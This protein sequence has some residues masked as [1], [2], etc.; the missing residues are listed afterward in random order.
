MIKN[1]KNIIESDRKYDLD[2]RPTQV[3]TL[4]DYLLRPATGFPIMLLCFT[5]L[6]AASFILG[7]PISNLLG[8]GL[9]RL[10]AVFESWAGANRF[11]LLFTSLIS[12]GIFRGIGSALAFFPQMLIFYVFYSAIN[13]TGYAQRMAYIMHSPMSR[14]NMDSSG[15]ACLFIGYSCNVPAVAATRDIPQRIDRLILMLVSTFTPCSARL[16]VILYIAAAFFTPLTA[17]LVMT[18]LIALS[19]AVSAAVA[20]AIKSRF[21][22]PEATAIKLTLPPLHRPKASHVVKSALIRTMDFLNKIKNVVI[23]SA[24]LV[25]FLSTFPQ[26]AGFEKSYVACWANFL[27]RWG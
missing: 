7:K 21:P 1:F 13:D 15:F 25:W 11:P 14:L 22:Q 2:T 9:D 20:F 23:I 16:G 8:L 6:F 27:N 26:G 3:K 4:D 24:V 17:T 19:W 18:S 5:A 12:N 10:V